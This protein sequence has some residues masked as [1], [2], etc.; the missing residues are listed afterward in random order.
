[1][2]LQTFILRQLQGKYL[3]KKRNLLFAF[4]DLEKAFDQLFRDDVQWALRKLDI[5]EWL[6][7]VVHSIYRDA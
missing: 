5:E 7:K 2:E 6:V 4:V 3:A 1:M